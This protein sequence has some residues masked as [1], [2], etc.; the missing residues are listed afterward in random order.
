MVQFWCGGLCMHMSGFSVVAAWRID[1]EWGMKKVWKIWSH[2]TIC[3]WEKREKEWS[4]SYYI[5][6]ICRELFFPFC[7]WRSNIEV[8][9]SISSWRTFTGRRGFKY[10]RIFVT[11]WVWR[12]DG[13]Q[14]KL[15]RFLWIQGSDDGTDEVRLIFQKIA[16]LSWK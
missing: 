16:F 12:E 8:G 5:K 1:R 6:F 10:F 2:R 15:L 13:F 9:S 3:N 11:A 14:S 7:L 4:R